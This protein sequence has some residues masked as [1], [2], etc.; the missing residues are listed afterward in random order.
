MREAEAT[1]RMT[2][3]DTVNKVGK[4]VQ[5]KQLWQAG[6][7]IIIAVSGGPDSMLLMHLLHALTVNDPNQQL[8]LVAAH[9]HHGFRAEESDQ[10]AKLVE[11]EASRLGVPY[12]MK[13]VDSPGY[14]QQMGLNP[15]AAAR[16]L[17]YEFLKEVAHAHGASCV[18]LAHHGDDQAETVLM[19]MIRGAGGVGLGGMAWSRTESNITYVRPLLQLRKQEIVELCAREG[20]I[21]AED[22]SNRKRTYTRNRIRMDILPALEEENPRVVNAIG[23]MAEVL[24]AEQAWMEEETAEFYRQHVTEWGLDAPSFSG[25]LPVTDDDSHTSSLQN[26]Q[27]VSY[28]L[29]FHQGIS[30][31]RKKFCSSHVALQRRL[32]KLILNYLLPEAD[33]A[34]DYNTIE[35]L[36][37]QALAEEPTT[38]RADLSN[39][40]QFRREY[41]DLLWV[42][43]EQQEPSL[44]V[45]G[46]NR[47]LLFNRDRGAVSGE[48][49][50]PGQLG[51]LMWELIPGKDYM[52]T[53]AS[54]RFT[55][56]FDADELS[57]PLQVRTRK[58]GDRIQVQGLKGSKK[59]QD[60]FVDCKVPPSLRDCI[61]ML[62]DHEGRLL[63]IPGI[64]RSSHA[65][66]TT[67]TA[68][69]LR[70]TLHV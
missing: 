13:R 38:W 63:W 23:Q 5:Q 11:A 1:E 15:Q 22:S 26:W 47:S 51:R 65:L 57:W 6:D 30:V 60:M 35:R 27:Q 25:S 20:I 32:I 3:I 19:H 12:V 41:D 4:L 44:Y 7:C 52:S 37:L 69:V 24:R 31:D 59:V 29:R 67:H 43:V 70:L 55:A 58:P 54:N 53:G 40:V 46:S 36:R 48:L 39:N 9:V 68:H 17:R 64:R 42:N 49:Q 33:Q 45:E 21:Y 14:A 18:A 2:W 50:L 56:L 28:R 62:E 66:T 10:E 34:V 16:I 8:R 61:P